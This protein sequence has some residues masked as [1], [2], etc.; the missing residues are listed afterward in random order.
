MFSAYFPAYFTHFAYYLP[1]IFTYSAYLLSYLLAYVLQIYCAYSTYAIYFAYFWKYIFWFTEMWLHIWHIFYIFLHIFCIFL[2]I[3]CIFCI[4][5][6]ICIC[7][8]IFC[9]CCIFCTR[10]ILSRGSIVYFY[11]RLVPHPSAQLFTYHHQ[12]LSLL[13]VGFSQEA[14]GNSADSLCITYGIV[15]VLLTW[16]RGSRP[17][18][19]DAGMTY[20]NCFDSMCL[21]TMVDWHASYQAVLQSNT[22]ICRICKYFKYLYKICIICQIWPGL[23][24][25]LYSSSTQT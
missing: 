22:V 18:M 13:S 9:I 12:H 16:T 14:P 24:W 3:F 11:H 8:F 10:Q 25:P 19:E 15:L 21:Y 20:K 4:F 1:D 2:C 5:V 6:D 23:L 7:I 17:N